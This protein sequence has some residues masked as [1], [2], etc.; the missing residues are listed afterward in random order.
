MSN[1]T[2]QFKVSSK[3]QAI[4]PEEND[5]VTKAQDKLEFNERSISDRIEGFTRPYP[6]HI[7]FK[8]KYELFTWNELNQSA[9]RVAGALLAACESRDRPIALLVNQGAA[10]IAGL[11][12]LKTG[13]FYVPLNDSYPRARNMYIL[14]ETK[15]PLILTDSK[16]LSVASELAHEKCQILN[17]DGLDSSLTTGNLGL[18]ISPDTTA[19]VTY[20]SGSTGEPKG[21]INTHNKVLHGVIHEKQFGLGHEDRFANVGSEGRTPFHSLLNGAGSYPWNVKDE[22]LEHLAEWLIGQEITVY[23]SGPRVFRQFVKTLNGKIH[24]PKLRVIILAGEPVHSADIELY[25]KHFSSDCLL[26]NTLGTHEVGPF[27]MCVINKKTHIAHGS[28]PVGYEIPGKEVLLLDDNRQV[29]GFNRVGEIAVKSRYLSPG[30]W[31]RPDLTEARF[32]PD[33]NGGD[34]LIY[35]TGDLG[36]ISTDGCLEHLGRK[37]FQVKVNG[38]RVDVSEVEKVLVNYPGVSEA[39]VNAREDRSGETRLVAYVVLHGE[40]AP[41]VSGLRNFLKEKLP[42]YM[43]PAAFVQL[44]KIPLTATGTTKVD[45][46]ALPDPGNQRP[47]LDTSYVVPGTPLEA[48]LASIWADIL[49]IDRAGIHDNFFDLGGHS[50][51]ASRVISHV[52]QTFQLEVPIKALFESPTI[53]KMA[54]IIEQNRTNPA[55]DAEVARMLCEVETMTDEEAEAAVKQ[56]GSEAKS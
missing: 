35:L 42:D 23:R 30:Y 24:F 38:F 28:V 51:A 21:V 45:R 46:R 15:P 18:P 44:D 43:I 48:A 27:R 4:P 20:T 29:V 34:E 36:R 37:D 41:T 6:D 33:P 7:A 47:N 16:H 31:R 40:H 13:G 22:G 53:A 19:F 14:N 39:V 17:I 32:I 55:G 8:T 5:R 12:V 26:I 1:P 25:K 56:L 50:L 3:E 9:N 49:S 2:H 54:A 52:I 10:I 11:G